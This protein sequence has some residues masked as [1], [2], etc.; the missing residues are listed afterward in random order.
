VIHDRCFALS[1]IPLR[2]IDI[3]VGTFQIEIDVHAAHRVYN[4]SATLEGVTPVSRLAVRAARKPIGT[5]PQQ[6][7][8]Q[9]HPPLRLR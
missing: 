6:Q 1:P 4:N 7:M 8:G 2:A 3:V 9:L 5:A